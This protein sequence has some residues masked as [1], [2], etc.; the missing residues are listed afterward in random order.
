M[1][2]GRELADKDPIQATEK[3]Y[4]A[5]RECIKVLAEHPRLEEVLARAREKEGWTVLDLY[6]DAREAATRLGGWVL[7]A[8]DHAWTLHVWSFPKA[9]L[10]TAAVKL[11]TPYIEKLVRETAKILKNT[12]SKPP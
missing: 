5:T 9:K 2:Q 4:K 10:N 3:L 11:R 7:D 8:W 1:R 6:E 12:G